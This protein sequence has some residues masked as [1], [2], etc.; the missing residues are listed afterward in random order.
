MATAD[1][2]TL[3]IVEGNGSIRNYPIFAVG[4]DPNDAYIRYTKKF[5]SFIARNVVYE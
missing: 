5:F 4:Q 1:D 2:Y 3:E